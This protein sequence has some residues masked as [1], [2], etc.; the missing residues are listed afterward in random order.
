MVQCPELDQTSSTESS[1]STIPRRVLCRQRLDSCAGPVDNAS[2]R[3]IITTVRWTPL[4][5]AVVPPLLL[6]SPRIRFSPPL[7]HHH[8]PPRVYTF[9]LHCHNLL[10]LSVDHRSD[11]HDMGHEFTA[12][13]NFSSSGRQHC[14]AE[15]IITALAPYKLKPPSAPQHH[16]AP[17][18]PVLLPVDH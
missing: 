15:L 9:P 12:P 16:H 18:P 1:P 17:H 11:C 10:S 14:S 3:K 7:S 13:V 5:S 4:R 2:G 8:C 6:T